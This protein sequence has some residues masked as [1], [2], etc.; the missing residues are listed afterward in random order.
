VTD[1]LAGWKVRAAAG[2][3]A[4]AAVATL[5]WCDRTACAQAVKRVTLYDG[6][7]SPAMLTARVG[8]RVEL[9]VVNAGTRTHN[10]VVRD[11]YV[12]SPNLAPGERTRIGFA[13]DRAG[14][15]R[16]YS[17]TG[18]RPE[19]GMTGTLRVMP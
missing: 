18:G 13:P 8:Q 12:F 9:E 19:P 5:A 1:K 3:A 11:F 17:D 15:F 6:R 16:Y 10:F 4:V 7:I 14:T 2:V